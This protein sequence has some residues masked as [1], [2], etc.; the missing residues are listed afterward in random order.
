MVSTPDYPLGQ[1]E[2]AND[3]Q[4]YPDMTDREKYQNLLANY[5][6]AWHALATIR[7]AI[8]EL[9]PPG[10]VMSPDGMLRRYRPEPVHEAQ[11]LVDALTEILADPKQDAAGKVVA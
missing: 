8:E 10:A 4:R 9:G 3:R 1:V 5:R 11:A 2:T 7:E 6:N